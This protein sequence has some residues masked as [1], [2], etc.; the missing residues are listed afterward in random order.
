MNSLKK[1]TY[2][3][4]SPPDHSGSANW[5]VDVFIVTLIF[6]N[7][8]VIILR[9]VDFIYDWWP[10]LFDGFEVF[11]I[12]V[13]TLEYLARVW[14]G[15]LHPDYPKA[16]LGNFRF[17]TSPMMVIDLMA[18]LPFYLPF[19]GLD[20]RFFRIMR[21]FRIFTILR[22]VR[23]T[24]SLD[25]MYKVYKKRISFLV[26]FS[27]FTFFFLILSSILLYYAENSTQPD[28]FSSIPKTMWW[29]MGVISSV[30][31]GEIAPMTILGRIIVSL[32]AFMA[33]MLFGLSAAV[34]ASG[35]SDIMD[36]MKKN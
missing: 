15:N 21:I 19:L 16:P 35:F 6:L 18:I 1:K 36:E 7:V 12:L 14:T 34:I 24:D 20:L 8:L 27:L 22:L 29:V 5:W 13:F 3:L 2:H 25:F 11:S 4:L 23:F 30:G 9:S 32:I 26:I 31:F 28:A 17:A 33:I 10:G